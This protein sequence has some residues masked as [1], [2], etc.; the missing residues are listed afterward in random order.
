MPRDVSFQQDSS[1]YPPF[2]IY[3]IIILH[4]HT[5]L[6]GK[7]VSQRLL[8][9]HNQPHI[10]PVGNAGDKGKLIFHRSGQRRQVI[11]GNDACIGHLIY[12]HAERRLIGDL[13]AGG[14]TDEISTP[15]FPGKTQSED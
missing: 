1:Q 13:L 9:R 6:K 10:R 5:N 11:H 12:L 4:N 14:Q 15:A 7:P 8:H 2:E 3:A